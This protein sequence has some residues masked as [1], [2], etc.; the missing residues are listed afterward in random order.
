MVFNETIRLKNGKVVYI[1]ELTINDYNKNDNY[2]FVHEWLR[3]VNKY[4]GQEFEKEQLQRDKKK[5]I[6]FLEN[7]ENTMIGAIHDD[8]IIGSARLTTNLQSK[9]FKH[10]ASCGLAIKKSFQK[11]GL[12]TNLL[13]KIEM[14]ALKKGVKKLGANYYEGNIESE[15]LLVKKMN[16]KEEGRLKYHVFLEN[17]IYVNRIL[18]GKFIDQECFLNR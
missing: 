2:S 1:K 12:G 16:I 17:G 11:Q 4:L 10:V 7:P 14:I 5:F 15:L 9:K 6:Q 3:D 18:L 13:K 8:K